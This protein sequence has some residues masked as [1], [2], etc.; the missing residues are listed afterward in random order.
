MKHDLEVI[1]SQL[2]AAYM[3]AHGDVLCHGCVERNGPQLSRAGIGLELIPCSSVVFC[4][5]CD[6]PATEL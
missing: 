3:T 1:T 2:G 6:C 4:S 5:L